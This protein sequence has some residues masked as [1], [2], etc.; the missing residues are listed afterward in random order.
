MVK[1]NNWTA[2]CGPT[3]NYG[4]LKEA[5]LAEREAEIAVEEAL[6]DIVNEPD[7]GHRL[8]ER[9]ESVD[10]ALEVGTTIEQA[11]YQIGTM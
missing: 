11:E 10:H 6:A 7:S 3:C 9:P 1:P 5:R 8:P 4:E 2:R